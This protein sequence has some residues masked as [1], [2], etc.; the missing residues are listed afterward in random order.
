MG[1]AIK[2]QHVSQK[3]KT[4]CWAACC[5]MASNAHKREFTQEAFLKKHNE[6]YQTDSEAAGTADEIKVVLGKVANIASEVL[7]NAVDISISKEQRQKNKESALAFANFQARISKGHV[8]IAGTS[9]HSV[10]VSGWSDKEGEHLL[11]NDPG[12]Q[13]IGRIKYNSFIAQGIMTLLAVTG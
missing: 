8:L 7:F 12:N 9:R 11:V 2:L 3:T 1:Q 13:Q 6:L 5:E 4:M 10:V